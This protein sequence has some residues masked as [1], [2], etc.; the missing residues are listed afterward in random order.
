MQ[1][2]K[3]TEDKEELTANE[4]EGGMNLETGKN[5]GGQHDQGNCL[6]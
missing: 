3:L 2:K 5:T 4:F 1:S 6:E